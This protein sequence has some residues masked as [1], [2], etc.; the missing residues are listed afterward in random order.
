M[1]EGRRDKDVQLIQRPSCNH[2]FHVALPGSGGDK[3]S[4]Q[5]LARARVSNVGLPVAKPE[6][7]HW[8]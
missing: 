5:A 6:H 8:F 4:Y 7:M 1:T 3:L 2:P